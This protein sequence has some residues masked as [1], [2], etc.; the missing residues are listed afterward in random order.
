M[1]LRRL[2]LAGIIGA[3]LSPANAHAQAVRV[4]GTVV[5]AALKPIRGATLR[6]TGADSAVTT[7]TDG[8]FLFEGIFPNGMILTVSAP[9]YEF[10][11]LPL[12]PGNTTLTISMRS[13][14]T[15]LDAMI[16]RPKTFRIRG[17]V[18]DSASGHDLL[19]ARVT[20]F[21]EARSTDAS[22]IGDFRFDSVG[23]GPI[24]IVAEAI[25]HLP[26]QVQFTAS[27]DTNVKIRMPVDLVARRMIG[28]QA[29][30]LEK[31]SYSTPLTVKSANR[32]DIAREARL[33]IGELVDK[34]L[35]QPW[36]PS[37]RAGI[38][39]DE[40]CVFYDDKRVPPGVLDGI[41]PEVIERV[42]IYRRGAM[43]RVYSKRYVMSLMGQDQLKHVFYMQA[44]TGVV[45]E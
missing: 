1:Q 6:L 17:T 22:N 16:V 24:T 44:G 21:P 40:A 29:K 10:R 11:S 26:V 23:A 12:S 43:I 30:R 14:I 13:S 19:F 7:G 27:R 42:E 28:V 38:P 5:D 4:N 18:V 20:L 8:A 45:C 34:M 31:R 2:F 32:Q 41:Y 3:G 33:N 25:E 37:R 35:L 9:G 36:Y 39:T 15:R